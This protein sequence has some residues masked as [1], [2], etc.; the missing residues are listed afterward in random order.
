[1]FNLILAFLMN[2]HVCQKGRMGYRCVKAECY[3][4]REE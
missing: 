2:L 4:R 1:M 3:E